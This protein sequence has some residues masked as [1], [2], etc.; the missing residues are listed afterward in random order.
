MDAYRPGRLKNRGDCLIQRH[1]CERGQQCDA[2]QAEPPADSDI[3][4]GDQNEAQRRGGKHRHGGAGTG[5]AR[6]DHPSSVTG[7][8]HRRW[9]GPGDHV[10]AQRARPERQRD[11]DGG[12]GGSDV[13]VVGDGDGRS[14]GD[15]FEAVALRLVVDGYL[16][17]SLGELGGELVRA[18]GELADSGLKLLGA[19]VELTS[20]AGGGVH[21]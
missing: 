17:A 11:R 21:S 14:G 12:Y 6:N 16:V 13:G 8:E 18:V 4:D 7:G 1:E 20:S 5:R 15:A 10:S 19:V 9:H 3:E 2:E